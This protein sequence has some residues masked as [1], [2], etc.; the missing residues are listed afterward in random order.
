MTGARGCRERP[1]TEFTLERCTVYTMRR[2]P[3]VQ[4]RDA[5]EC[6]REK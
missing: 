1:A 5:T 2:I 4:T 3:I 6:V